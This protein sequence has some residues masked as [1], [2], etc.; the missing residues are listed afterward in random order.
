[1]DPSI[2]SKNVRHGDSNAVIYENLEPLSSSTKSHDQRLL[3]E[4]LNAV[5]ISCEKKESDYTGAKFYYQNVC[6]FVE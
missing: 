6:H 4:A 2:D 1:M 5:I 3:R